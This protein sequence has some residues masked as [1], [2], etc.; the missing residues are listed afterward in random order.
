MPELIHITKCRINNCGAQFQPKIPLI[1]QDAPARIAEF[2]QNILV[3]HICRK[4]PEFGQAVLQGGQQFA[5]FLTL[6]ACEVTDPEL[7][8][9]A[10]AAR[11]ELLAALMPITLPDEA[12][13]QRVAALNLNGQEQ[14]VIDLVKEVRDVLLGVRAPVQTGQQTPQNQT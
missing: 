2:V 11:I 4:H 6:A 3:K 5:G 9:V 12:I 13:R 14:P 8:K 7:M 10:A 1:G